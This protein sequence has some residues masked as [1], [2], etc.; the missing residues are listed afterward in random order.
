[1][2]KKRISAILVLVLALLALWPRTIVFAPEWQVRVLD[3][4]ERPVAGAFVTETWS[5]YLY[6]VDHYDAQGQVLQTSKSDGLVIFPRKEARTRALVQFGAF[7]FDSVLSLLPHGGGAPHAGVFAWADGYGSADAQWPKSAPTRMKSDLHIRSCMSKSE[8]WGCDS[9]TRD[10]L[11]N[12]YKAGAQPG[13][14]V[15][16]AD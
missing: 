8:Q 7:L 4:N 3:E 14:P 11:R 12:L 9:K 2:S 10:M 13:S 15:F 1:V 6:V 5:H 16:P